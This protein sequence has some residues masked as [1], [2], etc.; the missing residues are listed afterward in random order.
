MSAIATSS[1]QAKAWILVGV[2]AIISA[3]VWSLGP[4]PQV[5]RR[6]DHRARRQPL[7][8]RCRT[9]RITT[10]PIRPSGEPTV[11]ATLTSLTSC[12]YGVPNGLNGEMF[13]FVSVMRAQKVAPDFGLVSFPRTDCASSC[14]CPG[15]AVSRR[16]HC[17]QRQ[18]RICPH[19]DRVDHN[20]A[21]FLFFGKASAHFLLPRSANQSGLSRERH[22]GN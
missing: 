13:F 2:C 6:E 17:I 8:G 12:R 19:R 5:S 10:L 3:V 1:S 18:R 15:R 14:F 11:N 9:R 21:F 4:I 7:T 20:D 16:A 22:Y